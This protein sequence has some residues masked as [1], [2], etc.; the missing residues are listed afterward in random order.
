MLFGWIPSYADC[1]ASTRGVFGMPEE[2]QKD[3]AITA[4]NAALSKK[5]LERSTATAVCCP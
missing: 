5:C 4:L 1:C 2:K 3:A